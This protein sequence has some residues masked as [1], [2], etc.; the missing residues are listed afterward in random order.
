VC[1]LSRSR[2][3]RQ[4]LV[5]ITFAPCSSQNICPLQLESP[6]CLIVRLCSEYVPHALQVSSDDFLRIPALTD[7][8]TL[9]LKTD[10][11]RAKWAYSFI[12]ALI[13]VSGDAEGATC[14]GDVNANHSAVFPD[15]LRVDD[16][17]QVVYCLRPFA[18]WQQSYVQHLPKCTRFEN[19]FMRSWGIAGSM[20][21]VA[22]LRV[23][24][25]L[26]DFGR[27]CFSQQ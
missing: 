4:C 1:G 6:Q 15:L 7:K 9:R 24:Q 17:V 18:Q 13:R 20:F 27:F 23:Q 21:I 12:A 2:S 26:V 25:H 10:V 11:E 16:R 8:F 14:I 5:L 3:R 22:S 19:Y